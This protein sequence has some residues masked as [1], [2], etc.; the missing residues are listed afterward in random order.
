MVHQ[1]P[2]TY[3][4]VSLASFHLF[5]CPLTPGSPQLFLPYSTV[6]R[7]MGDPAN[8]RSS[9]KGFDE[10]NSFEDFVTPTRTSSA[11]KVTRFLS[12]KLLAWGVEER[13]SYR[14]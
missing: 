14:I 3:D 13:G 4:T 6:N 8:M 1:L 9:A 12:E 2:H 10:K 11:S 7:S 5:N